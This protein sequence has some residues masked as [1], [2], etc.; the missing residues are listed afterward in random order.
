MSFLCN[1]IVHHSTP[2]KTLNSV[3]TKFKERQQRLIIGA[4]NL[5]LVF[6]A[7]SHHVNTSD[8]TFQ[9]SNLLSRHHCKYSNSSHNRYI[10][11]EVFYLAALPIPNIFFTLIALYLLPL[12]SRIWI[13]FL[14]A[15]LP[16]FSTHL[17]SSCKVCCSLSLWWSS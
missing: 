9:N 4:Q 11:T 13:S 7:Q 6:P 1:T 3:F 16:S 17:P 8:G 15:S 12:F 5:K 10:Q 2:I 14:G